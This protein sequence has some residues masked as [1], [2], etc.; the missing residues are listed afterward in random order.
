M[1]STLAAD[2]DPEASCLTTVR[3]ATRATIC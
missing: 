3:F 2:Q 1:Q